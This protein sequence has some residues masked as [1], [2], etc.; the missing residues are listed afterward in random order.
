MSDPVEA[1]AF[2]FARRGWNVTGTT[3]NCIAVKSFARRR[4]HSSPYRNFTHHQ[5]R[6]AIWR[7]HPRAGVAIEIADWR[8]FPIELWW[9]YNRTARKARKAARKAAR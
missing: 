5:A 1:A 8:G 9:D 7:P 6:V 3:Q 4:S 2:V